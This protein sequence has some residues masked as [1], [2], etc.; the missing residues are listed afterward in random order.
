M[1]VFN[2]H[3][4]KEHQ[5]EGWFRSAEDYE[6]QRERGLLTCPVCGNEK[7]IKG[8]SA[9]RLNVTASRASRVEGLTGSS[10]SL[11]TLSEPNAVPKV[12]SST[13]AKSVLQTPAI[14][15]PTI[16]QMQALWY[17]TARQVMRNTED[18][19]ENFAEEAR[20]IHYKESP[21]RAIRGKAT[22]QEAVE[23]REEGIDVYALA[24]PA[25]LKEPLQ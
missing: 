6:N 8:L 15:A 13:P 22:Q 18:V 24:I 5:F 2:L 12:D 25:S 17:E 1:I 7:V 20:K 4:E 14:N 10:T 11:S 23:L 19:G 21:E 16:E 3:C 9:P